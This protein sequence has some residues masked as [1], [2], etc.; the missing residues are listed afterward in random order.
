MVYVGLY[1][2]IELML[3]QLHCGRASAVLLFG[4]G[5]GKLS[6]PRTLVGESFIDHTFTSKQ[7]IELNLTGRHFA[8]ATIAANEQ[9]PCAQKP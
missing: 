8:H 9:I 7:S 4:A 1:I 3:K 2:P 5:E 6:Q